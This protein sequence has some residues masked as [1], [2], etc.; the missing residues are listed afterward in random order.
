MSSSMAHELAVLLV[1]TANTPMFMAE[2]LAVAERLHTSMPP[3]TIIDVLGQPPLG[4][5]MEAAMV[6]LCPGGP[7]DTPDRQVILTLTAL[8]GVYLSGFVHGALA[9]TTT[10]TPPQ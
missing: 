10:P 3:Q 6:Q 4:D 9:T 7:E 1:G 5:F 8:S 2:V